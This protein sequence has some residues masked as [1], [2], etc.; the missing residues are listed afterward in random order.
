M[1]GP[2]IKKTCLPPPVVSAACASQYSGSVYE[3]SIKIQTTG[4]KV[5][6][7]P[8][9]DT[10]RSSNNVTRKPYSSVS[11][12]VI[13]EPIADAVSTCGSLQTI[14]IEDG[15]V[16]VKTEKNVYLTVNDNTVEQRYFRTGGGVELTEVN[17]FTKNQSVL[18]YT[19]ISAPIVL[20]DASMSNN[21]RL[22]LDT[23]ATL[24]NATNAT[25]GMV[26]NIKIKQDSVGGRTL[27]FSST[28]KWPGGNTPVLTATPNAVDFLSMYYDQSDSTWVCVLQKG[29]A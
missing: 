25:D 19:L 28:Y 1:S 10:T 24:A 17:V 29:F 20:L 26:I 18:P 5:V 3:P 6:T 11:N 27:A 7:P 9:F 23:N 21:Y 14:R 16:T 13:S 22:T 12:R 4:H 8:A 2:I 15:E